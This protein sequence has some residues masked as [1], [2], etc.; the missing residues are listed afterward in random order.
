VAAA[1]TRKRRK[2]E[3]RKRGDKGGRDSRRARA[4]KD[5]GPAN[6]CG[7]DRGHERNSAASGAKINWGRGTGNIGVLAKPGNLGKRDGESE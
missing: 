2:K 3:N 5:A 7:R 6:R 4:P 1:L